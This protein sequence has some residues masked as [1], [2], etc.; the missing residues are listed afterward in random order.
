MKKISTNNTHYGLFD[1]LT[2]D[3]ILIVLGAS[4]DFFTNYFQ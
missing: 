3:A 2:S 1:E 4:Q